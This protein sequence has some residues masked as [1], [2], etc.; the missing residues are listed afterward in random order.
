VQIPDWIDQPVPEYDLD[1]THDAIGKFIRGSKGMEIWLGILYARHVDV[2]YE[3]ASREPISKHINVLS[4]LDHLAPDEQRSEYQRAMRD[5]PRINDIRNG[6]VHGIG[7][8]DGDL[9]RT[10][11]PDR[12]VKPDL[13]HD[14]LVEDYTRELLIGAGRRAHAIGGF[15]QVEVM[16]WSTFCG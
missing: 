3:K 6:L 2:S 12:S 14:W 1:P 5:A 7:W 10:Q 13:G 9:A 15:I 16:R 8:S 4:G 11:R